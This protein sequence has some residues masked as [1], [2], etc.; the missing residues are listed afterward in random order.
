[1]SI[2]LNNLGIVAERCEEYSLAQQLY[3]ESLNLKQELGDRLGAARSLGCLGIVAE[4]MEEYDEAKRL[5]QESVAIS[6]EIGDQRVLANCL[7]NLG[8]TLLMLGDSQAARGSFLHALEKAMEMQVVPIVLESLLGMAAILMKDGKEE[9]A[10]ELVTYVLY[11]SAVIH[12]VRNRAEDLI[13]ELKTRLSPLAF[14]SAQARG[15]TREIE[16]LV[17]VCKIDQLEA[18]KIDSAI[19]MAE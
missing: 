7:N 19:V 6:T 17:H 12:E 3:R 16:Y 9:S 18:A 13:S 1:M 14:E 5:H 11:H 2:T 8:F 4:H 10:V 15:K